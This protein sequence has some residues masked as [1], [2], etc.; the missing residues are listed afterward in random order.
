M[1]P[2]FRHMAEQ[3]GHAAAVAEMDEQI[4][5]SKE[6]AALFRQTLEKAA[7]RFA[8]LAKVEE[9]H[10]AHYRATLAKVGKPA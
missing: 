9:R 2:K 10:A 1:Y 8:A 4:V 5:E 7:K 3:E 6:H